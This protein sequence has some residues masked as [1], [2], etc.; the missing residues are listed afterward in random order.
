MYCLLSLGQITLVRDQS[1]PRQKVVL[2]Y[3][4]FVIEMSN[5][6]PA[7]TFSL[8][9]RGPRIRNAETTMRHFQFSKSKTQSYLIDFRR[10]VR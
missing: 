9:I 1:R 6:R 7:K 8:F 3:G 2:N 10:R 5:A 4:S